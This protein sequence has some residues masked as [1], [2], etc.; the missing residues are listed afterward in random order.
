[1]NFMQSLI[2]R[3]LA[4]AVS[5]SDIS[6]CNYAGVPPRKCDWSIMNYGNSFEISIPLSLL[7]KHVNIVLSRIEGLRYRWDNDKC[8]WL[9]EYG[10][11]P[12]ENKYKGKESWQIRQGKNAAMCAAGEAM[13]R[14]PHLIEDD[15]FDE[16]EPIALIDMPMRWCKIELRVYTDAVKGCFFVH[17]NR[18]TGDH[19]TYWNIWDIIRV[20]FQENTLFLSRVSFL[21]LAEVIEFDENNHI[22]RY[23]FNNLLVKEL[24][25]YTVL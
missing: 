20:Y 9:I 8:I 11:E 23:L 21:K 22:H 7:Q 12:M 13:F 17:F 1:M 2:D 10:T 14:F 19:S 6:N 16:D 18:M 4:K 5:F 25:T 24:C 3:G 15:D